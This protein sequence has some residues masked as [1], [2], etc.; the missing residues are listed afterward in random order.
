VSPQALGARVTA[1]PLPFETVLE[2]GVEI[3]DA[4]DAAHVKGIVHRDVKPVNVLVTERGHAK[5]LD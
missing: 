2:L 3:A 5:I 4:L 1:E